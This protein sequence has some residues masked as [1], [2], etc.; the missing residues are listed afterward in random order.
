[1]IEQFYRKMM[2][3]GGYPLLLALMTGAA[4]VDRIYAHTLRAATS[5]GAPALA[6]AQ[7][8]DRLLLLSALVLLAGV[9][10]VWL[11]HGV[12]RRLVVA[13]LLVFCLE[14]LAPL[15]AAA[16]PGGAFYFAMLGPALRIAILLAA[17][18]LALL[19]TRRAVA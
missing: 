1:M 13:S 14:F 16:V 3:A 8:A 17:L 11:L 5:D 10:S 18:G 2:L 19:A 6:A 7:V 15:I 12:A 4:W 9:M